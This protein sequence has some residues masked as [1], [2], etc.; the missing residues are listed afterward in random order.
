MPGSDL[1]D[2]G[3][4]AYL[5]QAWLPVEY[6][7]K[8]FYGKTRVPADAHMLDPEPFF[9]DISWHCKSGPHSLTRVDWAHYLD[10]AAK[11]WDCQCSRR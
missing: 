2:A 9:G 7:N 3:N 10:F 11:L 1:V 5:T 8:D 4:T 6:Q